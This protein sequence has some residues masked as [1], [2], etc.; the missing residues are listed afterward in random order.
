M[1]PFKTQGALLATLCTLVLLGCPASSNDDPEEGADGGAHAGDA[2]TGHDRDDDGDDDDGDDGPVHP[3]DDGDEP[4]EPGDDGEPNDGSNDGNGGDDPVEPNPDNPDDDPGS[5]PAGATR[6][7]MPAS[8]PAN[9]RAPRLVLD[10][11]GDLHAVYPAYAGGDAYYAF[12]PDNCN[13]PDALQAVRLPA[14]GTVLNAMLAV[15]RSGAPRVLLSTA[16]ELV[17][18]ECDGDCTDA[19]NWQSAVI[20]NHGGDRE[21]TGNALALDANDHP[22]FMMHTYVALLGIGQKPP[23]TFYAQCDGGCADAGS[24]QID[25]MQDQIWQNS[26]LRFDAQ[27]RAHLATVAVT[28]G[29]GGPTARQAAY[30]ECD[31]GCTTAEDWN[32]ILLMDA[33]EDYAEEIN[34]A[35]ALAL[36]ADGGPR[37]ALLGKT[38]GAPRNLAYFE[39]DSNCTVDNWR[40]SLIS[41]NAQLGSGVDIALDR[42]DNPRLAFTLA[43]NIGVYSCDGVDCAGEQSTWNLNKVEF[44]ADLPK[45]DIILWPNCTIDAWVLK[46]PSIVLGAGDS[47]RVGYQATDLSGGFHTSDPTK[48]A[49]LAGTDMTMS[50]LA[51]LPELSES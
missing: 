16:L 24:W 26:A 14:E 37:V 8:D 32:G 2:G 27:N 40:G 47:V 1:R 9:T 51:L 12:C 45:D 30:A 31:S 4:G 34:P 13:D 41:D 18:A 38:D 7:F 28:I 46:D 3:G 39:C 43:D 6:L 49:C 22:R 21:V 23:Q 50:R 48:P 25:A 11:A 44:A 35:I 15:T 33:F 20:L 19:A 36:T 42:N 10:A 29:S 5:G 17:W